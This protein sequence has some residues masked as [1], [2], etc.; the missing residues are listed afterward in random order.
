VVNFRPLSRD[1]IPHTPPR[2]AVLLPDVPVVQTDADQY[3]EL[4]QHQDLPPLVNGWGD[5]S[6]MTTSWICAARLFGPVCAIRPDAGSD[7]R[8][9]GERLALLANFLYLAPPN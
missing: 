9:R 4:A 3:R 2:W 7:H 5:A 6:W 8:Q 1:A